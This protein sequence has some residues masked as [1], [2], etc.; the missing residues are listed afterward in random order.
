MELLILLAREE[1]RMVDREA[2]VRRLWGDGAFIDIDNAINTAVRKIRRALDDGP[3]HPAYLET[4]VGKGY[5][6]R[7]QEQ[8]EL[9]A[10]PQRPMLVV[11]PFGNLSGDPGE[12]YFSDGLTEETIACLGALSPG[13]LGVIAR[14]TAMTY[15]GTDRTVARIGAEL[16]VDY[17]L[18]GS[19]RREGDR[20]RITMQLIRVADQTHL[21]AHSYDR[22][23]EGMVALQGEIAAAVAQQVQLRL[24]PRA[25][26]PVP[27]VRTQA[28]DDYLRGLYHQAKVTP[29]ELT[30]AI[31]CFRR[32]SERDDSYVAAYTGL[33]HC[34]IRLPITSDVPA[35]QAFPA[36][37]L[38]IRRA[39]ELDGDSAE[40][41][42]ADAATRFWFEWDFEGA[43]LAA[44][45]AIALNANYA[46]AQL[47]LAHVCSNL[48]EHPAALHAMHQAL[49]LDPLSL[50]ANAMHGQF[51]YHAGRHDE[52]LA[53]L[54]STLEL[55][56]R[57]WVAHICLAKVLTLLGRHDEALAACEQAYAHSGGNAEAPSITG[58]VH[59]AA[60]RRDLAL[61]T[62]DELTARAARTY[63][64]PY[65]IAL[66]HA[67]LG[68]TNAALHW[69]ER[70]LAERDVHMVFLCDP[71]WDCLRLLPRFRALVRQVGLP[72]RGHSSFWPG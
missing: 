44:Q 28:H 50:L 70:A 25:E 35:Q 34:Y 49:Q 45:R 42:T 3:D 63:V 13:H 26:V 65:D 52:A 7:I 51:L 72:E 61:R 15:R 8:A 60:G 67:G 14:T 58:Y 21:W 20:V 62:V 64:P 46:P 16:G 4:I 11:L 5:R 56:P 38:A 68:D 12:D 53:T 29:T 40:A 31:A 9:Q 2:I 59:A 1:G 41:H 37:R 33:A 17:A 71:K 36:A 30:R 39:L 66:I 47:C 27:P 23:A 32:A 10:P 19:T 22:R 69:L 57:F 55:E 54:Q 6:L 18:E 43:R 48:G 24:A